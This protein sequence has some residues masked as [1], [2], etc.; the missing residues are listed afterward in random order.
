MLLP[1]R[2]P[3]RRAVSSRRSSKRRLSASGFKQVPGTNE[4]L[5]GLSPRCADVRHSLSK[6]GL[7]APAARVLAPALPSCAALATLE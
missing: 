2:R 4:G 1:L 6:N 5:A 3:C 7:D